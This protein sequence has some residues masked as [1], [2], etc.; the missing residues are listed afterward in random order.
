MTYNPTLGYIRIVLQ[1]GLFCNILPIL[2][3]QKGNKKMG[4]MKALLKSSDGQISASDER[5]PLE[6]LRLSLCNKPDVGEIVTKDDLSL[7]VTETPQATK[8]L[9]VNPFG[10]VGS[11]WRP[12]AMSCRSSTSRMDNEP[13]T[14]TYNNFD[15]LRDLSTG[16]VPQKGR[17]STKV[18]QAPIPVP[19]PVRP[20][21]KST[22]APSVSSS[23]S[24]SLS[25]SPTSS[26]IN[27][28]CKDSLSEECFALLKENVS[29]NHSDCVKHILKRTYDVESFACANDDSD[30]LLL[31]L[32]Q[33]METLKCSGIDRQPMQFGMC[34]D[35]LI[36][37]VKCFVTDAKLLVSNATQTCDK[38]AKNLNQSMHTLAKVFLHCQATMLMMEAV[39]QAQHLG[40]EVIKVTNSYKSTVNAAHA[41]VGKPLGD[42]HM[43]Y[44]MRQ[45]T[46]LATLLSSLLK[47]LKTLEQK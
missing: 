26:L 6:P 14:H 42:P 32:K 34:R 45:A 24:S 22:P 41:A 37:Q 31:E 3:F 36:C 27:G 4:P 18:T 44:L 9:R 5:R 15:L 25:S 2:S 28:D 8:D 12:M 21:R 38:M 17:S 7:S 29:E 20:P 35:E 40:F 47:T 1:L 23:V 19:A 30:R 39:H 46:N 10:T 43:R 16:N 13:E 11:M 33:T